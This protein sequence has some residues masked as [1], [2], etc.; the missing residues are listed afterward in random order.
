MAVSAVRVWSRPVRDRGRGRSSHMDERVDHSESRVESPPL[1]RVTTPV[2]RSRWR[3]LIIL[4]GVI[5]LGLG[6]GWWLW[7]KHAAQPAGGNPPAKG[8]QTAP[9]PVGAATIDTGG[10]RIILD[11]L[12]TGTSLDTVTLVTQ[13]SGQL[14]DVA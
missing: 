12:G 13:I 11:E 9:Q 5:V 3:G 7:P 2:R 10:I 8:A 4:I 6:L 1:S 14:I